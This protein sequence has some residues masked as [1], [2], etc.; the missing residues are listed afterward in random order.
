M[1]FPSHSKLKNEDIPQE[2][3]DGDFDIP[4]GKFVSFTNKFKYLGTYLSQ[5]LSDDTDI[6]LR[7]IAA[8]KNFNAL[9]RTIFRNR[10]I[11]LELRCQ[12]YMAI[13]VNILLWGC[14]TWALMKSQLTKLRSFHHKCARQLFQVKEHKIKNEVYLKKTKLQPIDTLIHH[15]PTAT[16]LLNQSCR[17]GRIKTY[18]SSDELSRDSCYWQTHW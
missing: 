8:T 4:N 11:K 3:I 13:T 14:D 5:N 6:E 17:N 10:K 1:Y 2:L 16:I 7:I 12:M 15:C 18:P 9:G